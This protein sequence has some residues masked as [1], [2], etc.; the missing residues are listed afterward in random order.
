MIQAIRNIFSI[1][2]LRQRVLFTFMM[3]AVYRIGAHIPT[4]GIDAQALLRFFESQQ[5]GVLGFVDLFSGGNFSRLTIFALGIMPYITASII[6]QLLTVIWP[7]L[8]KLSKEGEAGRKKITQYTRYGTVVLSVVQ[9]IGIA[10]WLQSTGVGGSER[11]V[12]NPGAGFIFMTVVTLTT[13]TAF[14]MWLGE[15]ISDRGIGNGISLI[16]YAGIVVGFPKAVLQTIPGSEDT[17]QLNPISRHWSWWLLMVAVVAAIVS[18]RASAAQDPDPVLTTSLSLA[19]GSTAVQSTYLPLAGEH[20]RRH[21]GDFCLFDAG[22]S[23]DHRSDGTLLLGQGCAVDSGHPPYQLELLGAV[24]QRSIYFAMIVF[25][26]FFYVSIIFNP[27]DQAD[28]MK[29]YGG[30]IPGVRPGR[31]TAEYIDRILTRLTFGGAVYLGLISLLPM[32]LISGFRVQ[33]L[34]F[35]GPFFDAW[36]P[37]FVKQGLNVKFFFGGT[38]LLIVIPATRNRGIDLARGEFTAFLDSDDRALPDRLEKQ[39]AFL[40]AHPDHAAVGAWIEWMDEE[41][42]RLGKVKRKATSA[43]QIAAERLF[44]SCLENSAATARTELL[45]KYRHREHVELGSDYD[46]WAR[47]AADHPLAALPEVLV[48][49]RTHGGRTT[50]GREERIKE[51]RL[52]IFA[53]QLSA[54]GVSFDAKDLERHY[55]LRRMH[56]T[57][58]EPHAAYLAWAEAWLGGLQAANAVKRL[59]PEPAFT[60]V[61]GVF[62]VKACWYGRSSGAGVWRRLWLS[63]LRRGVWP[64]LGRVLRRNVPGLPARSGA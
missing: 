21:P 12:L 47:L 29:K 7:Y 11:I 19:D 18:R 22:D 31:K 38:S 17:D 24:V 53:E 35:V 13:G 57:G 63:P 56:K 27:M 54:L 41:G 8:E 5:A 64:A 45:R 51:L 2:E 9:S 34:P 50:R 58:F 30:F 28:N 14:I 32:F 10:M 26:C 37:E 55:L 25:F 46:L 43:Q 1:P 36:V 20:G 16:I 23:R 52:G 6:L 42:R 59:Y 48:L 44:R 62:W 3:L 4:P 49:R 60:E 15:Q 61:L 33:M 39:V 40:D